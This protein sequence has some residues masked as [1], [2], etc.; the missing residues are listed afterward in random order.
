MSV[1]LQ[2]TFRN[3]ANEYIPLSGQDVYESLVV[4]AARKLN[5]EWLVAFLAGRD[6]PLEMV[7]EILGEFE[8]L[9]QYLTVIAPLEGDQG[10][11]LVSRLRLV[12]EQLRVASVD[13]EVVEVWIG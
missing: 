3:K 5:A 1:A 7:V 9:V 13:P 6:V 10:A 8:L 4:P 2:L 12:V 11:H